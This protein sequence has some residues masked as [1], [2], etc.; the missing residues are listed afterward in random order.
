MQIIGFATSRPYQKG[1]GS[2]ASCDVLGFIQLGSGNAKT[3][4]R[5]A[6]HQQNFEQQLFE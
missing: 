3:G 5:C 1:I 2:Q 6:L 4:V